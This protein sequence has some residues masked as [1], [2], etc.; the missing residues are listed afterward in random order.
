MNVKDILVA[1]SVNCNLCKRSETVEHVFMDCWD[2]LLF[3]DVL[4]GTSKNIYL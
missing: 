2:A 3:W 4:N 1:W